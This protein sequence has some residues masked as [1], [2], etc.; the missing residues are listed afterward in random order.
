MM[1]LKRIYSII[2]D[3]W[4]LMFIG[5]S[6]FIIITTVFP[7]KNLLLY[8]SIKDIFMMGIVISKDLYFKN[9]SLGKKIFKLEIVTLRNERPT[10]LV[11]I[12]RNLTIIIWPIEC[13]LILIGKERIGDRLCKTKVVEKQA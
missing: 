12:L 8:N 5:I 11:K 10:N 1:K 3:C 2:F 7:I 9:G 4:F 13:V 6:S